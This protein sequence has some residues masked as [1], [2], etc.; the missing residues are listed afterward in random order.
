MHSQAEG[1]TGRD[2]AAGLRQLGLRTSD[3]VMVHSSLSSFGRVEGGAATVIRALQDVVTERGVLLLP[4]FNHFAPFVDS[5]PGVYDPA[6]TPSGN[7]AIPE[8]FRQMP[9]VLRSLNPSHPFAAWGADARRYLERHHLALTMGPNSPLGLLARDGGQ[10]LFLGTTHHTNSFKHVVE[11]SLGAPCI[12]RR[13][14]E[15]PVRVPDG[16]IVPLRTWSWRERNCSES[17]RN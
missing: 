5:G 2:I 16:R 7:G 1:L 13:T 11:M 14:E 4:S 12:G 10:C 3:R 17:T 8:T 15:L 9:G 6:R